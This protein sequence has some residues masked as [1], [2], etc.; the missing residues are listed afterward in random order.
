MKIIT[1]SGKA[2]SGKDTFAKYLRDALER[3]GSKVLVTHYA[4]LLK[5]ILREFFGWN[6]NKD[7]Y[8]RELLQYVGTDVVR[9]TDPDFWV[10]FLVWVFKTFRGEWDYILIP[11]ARFPNEIEI[12]KHEFDSVAVM[13]RREADSALTADAQQHTSETALD[14]YVGFDH[15]LENNT[16]HGLELRAAE[17]ARQLC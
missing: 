16:L 5:Y 11:D 4:D 8:G 12:M 6:G 10:N 7:E 1:I 17:L 15:I 13:I 3:N 9:Q 2:G 14:N